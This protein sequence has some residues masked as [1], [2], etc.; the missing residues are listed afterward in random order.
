MSA[1]LM[2]QS[3]DEAMTL[4][5]DGLNAV[6]EQHVTLTA[7]ALDSENTADAQPA[8]P[9]EVAVGAEAPELPAASWNML[10]FR[11]A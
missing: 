10:R 11:L 3:L 2:H 9:R 1:E 5:L 6:L 4:E 8:L 7:P